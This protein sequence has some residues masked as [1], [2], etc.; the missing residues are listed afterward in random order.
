[1]ALWRGVT[2]V[3]VISGDLS[4]PPDLSAELVALASSV[5]VLV[6]IA[7]ITPIFRSIGCSEEA[8]RVSEERYRLLAERD[9]TERKQAE[10]ALRRRNRELALLNRASQ[11][12]GSTLDLDRVLA[13]VLEEVRYLLN[14]VASSVWLIDKETG[15]LVCLHATGPQSDVVRGWRLS[16]G[17]GLVGWVAHSGESQIVPDARADGRHFVGVDQQSGLEMRSILSVP[18]RVKEDVIG[19]LQVLDTDV[20]RFDAADLTLLESLAG[21]AAIAIDNARL[22]E[23]QRQYTIRLQAR[24][25]DLDAFAHTVAHDLKN[26][27]ALVVGLA[28]VLREEH[29][30]L[31]DGE[32]HRYLYKIARHG[33]SMSNIIDELLLLAGV[34]QMEVEMGSLDMASIVAEAQERLAHVIEEQQAEIILPKT[35]PVALGYGPWVEEVWVNYLS[36]ALKYGG[37]PPRVE[38]GSTVGPDGMVCFWVRDNGP[39]LAPEAQAR[40]FTPFTRFDQVRTTGYGLGLSIVRRIVEKLGGQVRGESKVGR[41]SVFSFTLPAAAPGSVVRESCGDPEYSHRPFDQVTEERV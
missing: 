3:R 28:E 5:A 11:A 23:A 18:L 26:P 33:R 6:G 29:A 16:L 35:W 10:Q 20:D 4:H 27:L 40:L 39:G 24:N 25:E 15:E 41:G 1:M 8:L 34:R 12:F 19:V 22:V 36:N 38:L 9:V 13:T 30:T 32:R 2:L 21:S 31:P 17:E 7:R 14:V 37:R